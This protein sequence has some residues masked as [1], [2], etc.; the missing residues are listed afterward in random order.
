MFLGNTVSIQDVTTSM[1]YA[2]KSNGPSAFIIDVSDYSRLVTTPSGGLYQFGTITFIK[3][4]G[5]VTAKGTLQPSSQTGSNTFDVSDYIYALGG[6][7]GN[8]NLTIA[9][10]LS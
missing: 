3:E 5:T 7:N 2:V 6:G 4:D 1:S 9:F 10:T 8:S